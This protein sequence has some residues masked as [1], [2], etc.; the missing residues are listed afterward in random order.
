VI[1]T[2][3][4]KIA[5]VFGIFLLV[6]FFLFPV[7]L[8]PNYELAYMVFVVIPLGILLITDKERLNR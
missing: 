6:L 7:L 4:E 1:F 5:L 8:D 3:R 2:R